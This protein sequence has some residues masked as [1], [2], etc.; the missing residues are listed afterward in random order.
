MPDQA[1]TNIMEKAILGLA[2]EL[3]PDAGTFILARQGEVSNSG[4]DHDHYVQ[5]EVLGYNSKKRFTITVV[6]HGIRGRIPVQFFD[7]PRLMSPRGAGIEEGRRAQVYDGETVLVS[8]RSKSR[9][10]YDAENCADSYGLE[11]GTQERPAFC[12]GYM[13]VFQKR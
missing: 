11:N 6:E 5:Y 3:A 12:E 2:H 1:P 10:R 7:G 9:T 8:G 4:E 13:S